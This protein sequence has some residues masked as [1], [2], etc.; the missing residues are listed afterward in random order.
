MHSHAARLRRHFGPSAKLVGILR[1]YVADCL[2]GTAWLDEMIYFD[3][4]SDDPTMWSLAVRRRM[5]EQKFDATMP[6]DQFVS[7]GAT[8]LDERRQSS[9]WDMCATAAARC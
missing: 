9:A 5:R 2:A 1:P 3:R 4:R 8:G 7:H 6:P